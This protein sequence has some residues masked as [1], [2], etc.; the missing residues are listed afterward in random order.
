MFSNDNSGVFGW[1]ACLI[2][3]VMV[4]VGLS[5]VVD[6]RFQF[7][8]NNKESQEVIAKDAE[9]LAELA[10]KKPKQQERFNQLERPRQLVSREADELKQRLPINRTRI[11]ELKATMAKLKLE[12]SSQEDAMARYRKAYR[13]QTWLEAVGEKHPEIT[14]RTGRRYEAT[15]I[16]RVT[17]VGLEISYKDGRARI[18]F[19]DLDPSWQERFQWRHDERETVITGESSAAEE[20]PMTKRFGTPE[21]GAAQPAMDDLRIEKLRND[22]ILWNGKASALESQYSEAASNAGSGRNSVPGALETWSAKAARLATELSRA[23]LQRERAR[24]KLE[25]A[26]PNDPL[27]KPLPER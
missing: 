9:Y 2:V 17:P 8:S 14:L 12:L 6:R 1:L 27:A 23:K 16:L 5:L 26:A 7:S 3:I 21:T 18:D 15:S 13:D 25:A 24:V 22:V 4:G 19:T 20:N 11:E 10:A